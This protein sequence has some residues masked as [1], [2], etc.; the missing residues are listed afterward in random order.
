[1]RACFVVFGGPAHAAS[2]RPPTE[3]PRDAELRPSSCNPSTVLQNASHAALRP[4]TRR[5]GFRPEHT[6]YASTHPPRGDD[7]SAHGAFVPALRIGARHRASHLDHALA[8]PLR[9]DGGRS[10]AR[11]LPWLDRRA[12]SRGGGILVD[13]PRDPH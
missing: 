1:V 3:R 9:G 7:G 10:T 5:V 11:L 4:E 13:P 6:A 8:A 12:H 2:T